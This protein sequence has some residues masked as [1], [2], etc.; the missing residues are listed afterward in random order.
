MTHSS[1]AAMQ[2][3]GVNFNCTFLSSSF[4][5]LCLGSLFKS[6]VAWDMC[7]RGPSKGWPCGKDIMFQEEKGLL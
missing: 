4:W 6:L 7:K 5:G 3:N 2:K 1:N